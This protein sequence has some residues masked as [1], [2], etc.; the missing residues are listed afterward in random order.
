MQTIESLESFV[1]VLL[2]I[3][4]VA[5]FFGDDNI[6]QATLLLTIYYDDS[7]KKTF[8]NYPERMTTSKGWL[9]KKKVNKLPP[10]LPE[11]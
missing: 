9:K 4:L 1:F 5:Y 3:I 10:T 8:H 2:V 11:T 6:K 7:N